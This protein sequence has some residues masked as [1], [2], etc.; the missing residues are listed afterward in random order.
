MTTVGLALCC[1]N[2]AQW[3]AETIESCLDQ[4][5]RVDQIVVVDDGSRD[6]SVAIAKRYEHLGVRV[7]ELHRR[8]TSVA[9]NTGLTALTTD[10]AGIIACDDACLPHR[11]EYQLWHLRDSGADLVFA[12]PEVIDETSAPAPDVA[13]SEF[14]VGRNT[15]H[16]PLWRLFFGGNFLCAPTAFGARQTMLLDGGFH[17][18]LLQVQ[19]FELWARVAGRGEIAVSNERIVRYRRP[20]G[21]TN[22]SAPA[23]A[24]RSRVEVL[25]TFRHFFDRADPERVAAAFP[26]L[27]PIARD[28]VARDVPLLVPLLHFAHRDPDVRQ[29]GVELLFDRCTDADAAA[30]LESVYGIAPDDVFALAASARG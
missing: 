19:D 21:L 13:A 2:Q 12:M 18:A 5:H 4:T 11:I 27:P 23:N 20:W 17:P 22:I 28:D 24:A 14:F 16:P 3:V 10:L 1:F 26:E 8:G 9:L 6:D 25:Y 15:P 30:R 29:Q 7:I